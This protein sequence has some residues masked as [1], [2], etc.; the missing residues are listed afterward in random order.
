MFGKN[1]IQITCLSTNHMINSTR[2]MLCERWRES[3]TFSQNF[4]A[5]RYIEQLELKVYHF[6]CKPSKNTRIPGRK[7]VSHT[8]VYQAILILLPVFQIG[9]N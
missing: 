8:D 1:N 6:R 7:T 4:V 9:Y 3:I 5:L 2:E